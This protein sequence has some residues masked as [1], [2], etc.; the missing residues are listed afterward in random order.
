[1]DHPL[2]STVKVTEQ[3]TALI[4][5]VD[6]MIDQALTTGNPLSI[7]EFGAQ[8]RQARHISGLALAKLLFRLREVWDHFDTDDKLRDVAYEHIGVS[9]YTYQRYIDCW[10]YVARDRSELWSKPI[11]G[12]L[13]CI[14]AAKEDQLTTK[15]WKQIEKAPNK[16]TI[17]DLIKEVRGTTGGGVNALRI[18]LREDGALQAVIGDGVYEPVGYIER[19]IDNK[20]AIAVIARFEKAGLVVEAAE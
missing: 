16:A 17:R 14:A 9:G 8:L 4:K 7:L 20:L 18:W 10:E 11:G 12:L 1:M 3:G 19:S 15:H 13:L 6:D 2:D 5:K